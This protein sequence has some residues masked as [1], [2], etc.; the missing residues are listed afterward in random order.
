MHTH[1]HT[2]THTYTPTYI[3]VQIYVSSGQSAVNPSEMD[4]WFLSGGSARR[5][6]DLLQG[7]Q[8]C[9]LR[10][11]MITIVCVGKKE[12]EREKERG[13]ESVC[14][15]VRFFSLICESLHR[16]LEKAS[17]SHTE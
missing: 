7:L 15:C 2:H 10:F 13:R 11:V 17:P 5:S 3:H 1:T 14:V 12:K 6:P 8:R 9:D 16:P 4:F